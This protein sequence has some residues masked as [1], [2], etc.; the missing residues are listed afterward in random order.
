MEA[1]TTNLS[2]P[3]I[4]V[5]VGGNKLDIID[6]GAVS[7]AFAEPDQELALRQ[8]AAAKKPLGQTEIRLR[9][10][11]GFLQISATVSVAVSAAEYA[12]DDPAIIDFLT[13][14]RT[15]PDALHNYFAELDISPL[16]STADDSERTILYGT[17]SSHQIQAVG[18]HI[19]GDRLS[20]R[21]SNYLEGDSPG[22]GAHALPFKG[23]SL[24][25]TSLDKELLAFSKHWLAIMSMLAMNGDYSEPQKLP[26]VV[27][28]PF[29][30]EPHEIG[31]MAVAATTA[32]FIGVSKDV[33]QP[34]FNKLGGMHQAKEQAK[35]VVAAFKH[36]EIMQKWG[37]NIPNGILL[38]GPPGTGK[39][40]LGRALA[41]ELGADLREVQSAEILD[42]Y[43]GGSVK[44]L[45][46]VFKEAKGVKKPTVYMFD[47]FE[48]II[49]SPDRA[50]SG[51]D[52]ERQAMAGIFKTE[53]DNL[54]RINPNAIFVALTNYID[55]IDPSLIRPGRFDAKIFVDNPNVEELTEI[56]AIKI[57]ESVAE[58]SLGIESDGFQMFGDDLDI[59]ALAASSSDA[60][61][62]GAHITAILRG[63][64]EAKAYLEISTGLSDP[65]SQAALLDAIR[66]HN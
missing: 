31:A 35:K 28:R 59:R 40:S 27:L 9:K 61:H 38:Y 34:T 66:T 14:P 4:N 57:A 20:V 8:T 5:E 50:T 52:R 62:N 54:V 23:A 60:D 13:A 1:L 24:A 58:S 32:E 16:T 30:L 19:E 2:S 41:F 25:D 46:A 53:M 17:E 43:L 48:T 33:H 51:G 26:D 44:N 10:L 42:K 36:P 29:R 21:L 18:Y 63:V 3:R 11:D 64:R 6:I 47:E 7:A 22:R 12:D 45:Q 49:T 39:T 65:I 56:W 55:R 15:A 37:I